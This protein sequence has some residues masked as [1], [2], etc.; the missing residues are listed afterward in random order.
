M[1]NAVTQHVVV[2]ADLSP[3]AKVQ[4]TRFLLENDVKF[5]Q[6]TLDKHFVANIRLV[7]PPAPD[8]D[9]QDTTSQDEEEF[10]DA[11]PIDKRLAAVPEALRAYSNLI[12][13]IGERPK[14]T[15]TTS[16]TYV[17]ETRLVRFIN[18]VYDARYEDLS[19][20]S[21]S[22]CESFARFIRHY[23]TNLFGLKRLVDQQAWDLIEG[24]NALQHRVDV[25]LFSCFLQGK[26]PERTLA[27]FLFA[28][29]SLQRVVNA[30]AYRPMSVKPSTSKR[31]S[32]PAHQTSSLNVW[33]SRAQAETL[34]ETVF[35]SKTEDTYIEFLHAM[36][37]FLS[38]D[39]SIVRVRTSAR[40]LDANEF[41]FIA[42]ETYH[43][44]SAPF[45][46]ARI[47]EH[48]FDTPRSSPKNR[49]F[50]HFPFDKLKA[51]IHKEAV[52]SDPTPATQHTNFRT[53]ETPSS[54]GAAVVDDNDEDEAQLQSRLGSLLERMKKRQHNSGP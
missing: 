32:K 51:T 13:L 26:Y 31:K 43:K 40:L 10:V 27:F 7:K 46:G 22:S 37:A 42:T 36:K 45:P 53:P 17:K 11:D 39:T 2:F 30:P 9:D 5:H 35:G 20:S 33:L 24:L 34:A 50:P 44:S 12:V 52:L 14:R 15:I 41:L 38:C 48:G 3:Q 16:G 6:R 29:A 49:S 4:Y 18:E 23:L 8:D 25:E 19:A 21:M 54:T 28:R 47:C 1:A